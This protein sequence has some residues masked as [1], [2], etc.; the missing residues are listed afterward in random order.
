[1]GVGL[2]FECFIFYGGAGEAGGDSSRLEGRTRSQ[3]R[4][5]R[6]FGSSPTA[7]LGSGM[8]L[9]LRGG[10]HTSIIGGSHGTQNTCTRSM[11]L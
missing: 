10:R 9:T 8:R 3:L 2:K 11:L 6:P 5:A 4:V 1:M 7:V